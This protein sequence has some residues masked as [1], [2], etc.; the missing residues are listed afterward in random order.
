MKLWTVQ[1]YHFW[2]VLQ[3][4]GMLCGDLSYVNKDWLPA[5]Q[6]LATQM[7]LRVGPRPHERAFPVWAWYQH[8]SQRR[9]KPDLRRSGY[10]T[11]G[12]RGVRIEFEIEDNLVLLSDFY[13]WHCVLNNGYLAESEEDDER[14]EAEVQASGLSYNQ[15]CSHPDYH[16]QI[17]ASWQR[18]FDLDWVDAKHWMT[19]QKEDKQIQGAFWE[20]RMSDV[21]DV[22]IFVAR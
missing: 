7:E 10:M 22:T 13:L 15:Y 4:E 1:P 17:V 6:W 14:F 20:L 16:Q 12:Q 21:K 11:P 18:V 8:D 3:E 19:F 9:K 5:Y 2:E